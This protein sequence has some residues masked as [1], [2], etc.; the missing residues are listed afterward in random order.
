MNLTVA[1]KEFLL[2][3]FSSSIDTEKIRG[4]KN[5]AEKLLDTGKCIVAGDECIWVGS[6]GNFNRTKNADGAVGCLEYSFDVENFITSEWFKSTLKGHKSF[7]KDELRK[8]ETDY[9]T[10]KKNLEEIINW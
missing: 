7:V 9:T 3:F 2:T 8:L 6:I 1:Q 4:W 5:I 10:K